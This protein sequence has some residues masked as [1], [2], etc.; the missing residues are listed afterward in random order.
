MASQSVAAKKE[1]QLEGLQGTETPPS[2]KY[3]GASHVPLLL[4]HTI[5]SR[6]HVYKIPLKI[7]TMI[8]VRCIVLVLMACV[9]CVQSEKGDN[10][11]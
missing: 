7:T 11:R 3:A 5:Q 4:A 1:A 8:T 10:S 6:I 2:Q 9:A